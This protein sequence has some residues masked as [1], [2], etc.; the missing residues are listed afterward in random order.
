MRQQEFCRLDL[1][2][3]RPGG[4]AEE[5]GPWPSSFAGGTRTLLPDTEVVDHHGRRHR[6]Y[7][8]LVRGRAVTLNVMFTGC[9]DTCPLVTANLRQVQELLGHRVGRDL[10]MYS[11]TLTP[12][13]ETPAIL[14]AY[15]ESHD[16]G[17][18]WLF[19]TGRP[20]EI[21]RLR[22]A[23]GFSSVDPELDVLADQHTGFLRFGSE[24]LDRWA[25][26]PALLPSTTIAKAILSSILIE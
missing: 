22:D 1:D 25:G 5:L 16:V 12:E 4:A 9:G 7:A 21:H 20:A 3:A 19:L 15:A 2:I 10:F 14:H 6:F 18:G 24:P 11:I 8:D 17:P 23:L 13:L 26:C